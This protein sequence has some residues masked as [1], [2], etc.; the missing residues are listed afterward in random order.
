MRRDVL[1]HETRRS[2][3]V[4]STTQA[5]RERRSEETGSGGCGAV[6]LIRVGARGG[7][8]RPIHVTIISLSLSH[9]HAP[10]QQH[11]RPPHVSRASGRSCLIIHERP[12]QGPPVAFVFTLCLRLKRRLHETTRYM[13]S[14]QRLVWFPRAIKVESHHIT[15]EIWIL[16]KSI[17]YNLIIKLLIRETNLL[18]LID[19]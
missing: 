6:T 12:G 1:L 7:G 2:G 17:K 16:I 15:S 19:S 3:Q 11:L 9:A 8:R 10:H 18:S 13:A 5:G 14:P 4:N